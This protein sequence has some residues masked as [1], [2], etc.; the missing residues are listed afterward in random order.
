MSTVRYIFIL[1]LIALAAVANAERD[2]HYYG[3]CSQANNPPH[4][5]E[6]V[7]QL[8]P[9]NVRN[10]ATLLREYM[11]QDERQSVGLV[12][13]QVLDECDMYELF[14]AHVTV[15]QNNKEQFDGPAA[16]IWKGR[17]IPV[18]EISLTVSVDGIEEAWQGSFSVRKDS[19][20]VVVLVWNRESD[21]AF[22]QS[23]VEEGSI[24]WLQDGKIH[25]KVL[26]L[27]TGQGIE[28]TAVSM[29]YLTLSELI[30]RGHKKH[31][32]PYSVD[33]LLPPPCST[34]TDERGRFSFITPMDADWYEIR[35]TPPDGPV[36]AYDVNKS[37]KREQKDFRFYYWQDTAISP[38]ESLEC[39]VVR[40]Y[41]NNLGR[42]GIITEDYYTVPVNRG[43]L[44]SPA[45]RWS[46]R[47]GPGPV[48]VESFSDQPAWRDFARFIGAR[49]DILG[50]TE[51]FHD[52]ARL[53]DTVCAPF[54]HGHTW[55]T[56]EVQSLQDGVFASSAQSS[57]SDTTNKLQLPPSAKVIMPEITIPPMYYIDTLPKGIIYVKITDPSTVNVLDSTDVSIVGD[58]FNKSAQWNPMVKPIPQGRY[59]VTVS[60]PHYNTVVW[61][62]VD[63][64]KDSI[65]AFDVK[66]STGHDTA[67]CDQ[68]DK[69]IRRL[70]FPEPGI[71][72]QVYD[73]AKDKPVSG[74]KIILQNTGNRVKTD[75]EGRF[76][77][78]CS[79]MGDSLILHVWR[80][81]YDSVAFIVN[82][83]RAN[84]LKPVEI[85]LRSRRTDENTS[86]G[87]SSKAAT[88]L[89]RNYSWGG[90]SF[91]PPHETTEN[92]RIYHVVPGEMFRVT[93]FFGGPTH[94]FRFL[95]FIDQDRALVQVGGGLQIRGLGKTNLVVVG[96]D[97]TAVTTT[98]F[99]TGGVF[100]IS[101]L[102]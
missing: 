45:D 78:P 58:N 26:D 31:F 28:N 91:V 53:P 35:V 81:G 47:H 55:A 48:L 94:A 68:Y 27:A 79:L 50:R 69:R 33:V 20:V 100:Y 17:W 30:Q 80:R 36:Y 40:I 60:R 73:G 54:G 43:Q 6:N 24:P 90:S 63:L 74:A 75:K 52:I 56:F 29:R 13:V 46:F 21:T 19:K 102:H 98:S 5:K 10:R 15:D 76:R 32:S 67:R 18:G 39:L 64:A 8:G 89:I 71:I 95:E 72:G 70:P 62:N 93:V 57:R 59:T 12:C 4:T 14:S 16:F 23:E 3:D 84:S 82:K 61:E 85:T 92:I 44:L 86:P 65:L 42:K 88:F 77:L 96:R 97:Q 66:M 22:W 9:G 99:D 87:T 2:E 25:G 37:H 7:P 49:Y 101:I 1:F 11:V 38:D 51:L 34:L 41:R 83:I